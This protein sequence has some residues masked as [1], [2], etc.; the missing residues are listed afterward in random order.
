MEVKR[1]W[2]PREVGRVEC[3]EAVGQ[4]LGKAS[5]AHPT[6]VPDLSPQLIIE[7]GGGY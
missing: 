1:A 6:V 3:T 5:R 7:A 2:K 4:G